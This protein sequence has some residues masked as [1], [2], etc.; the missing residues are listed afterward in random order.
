MLFLDRDL[1]RGG[2]SDDD[3]AAGAGGA[4]VV[5]MVGGPGSGKTQ[6]AMQLAVNNSLK[7]RSTAFVD[8]DASFSPTRCENMASSS[9][10]NISVYRP[11]DE[12][13]LVSLLYSLQG[14]YS[15]VVV[16]SV[17]SLFR[18]CEPSPA[19]ARLVARTAL[20][21]ST[22]AQKQCVVVVTN[23]LTTSKHGK[24]VPAL[25]ETWSH[26]ADHK[27]L[28][29]KTSS[30]ER[31]VVHLLKSR[32]RPPTKNFYY[33][34]VDSKGIREDTSSCDALLSSE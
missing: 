13:E 19:K 34:H 32:T 2:G 27:Y 33:F 28:V 14:K 31:R 11:F 3:D 18:A 24:K 4:V 1:A 30:D 29:E 25:G 17:A 20:L 15:L 26:V 22:I 21:L 12:L 8:A 23:Q 10:S 16:D 9:L 5:E 7:G 6:I